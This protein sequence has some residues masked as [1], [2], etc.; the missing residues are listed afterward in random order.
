MP[1]TVCRVLSSFSVGIGLEIGGIYSMNIQ[2]SY[3]GLERTEPVDAHIRKQLQ[4]V[5][6]FLAHDRE[7]IRLNV[8]VTGH[9][10]HAHHEVHIH[11]TSALYRVDVK[12]EGPKLY[13]VIDEVIDCVYEQ[14]RTEKARAV[15]DRKG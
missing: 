11:G 14:L 10:N 3:R 5:V 1:I 2:I 7:P 9:P 13:P 4:K 15:H 6:D 12:R 8:F